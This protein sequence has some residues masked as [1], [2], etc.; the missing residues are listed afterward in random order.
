MGDQLLI[1]VAQAL[2]LKLRRVDNLFRLGG[3]E[4]VFLIEQVDSAD[5]VLDLTRRLLSRLLQPFAI[6]DQALTIGG[7][8]GIKLYSGQP[9]QTID[10]VLADAD[11]TMYRA[12]AQRN[13][14]ACHGETVLHQ[15][16]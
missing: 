3:D 11:S 4:F 14:I 8:F 13:C 12:K 10:Q 6:D 16:S 1:Q 9:C 15:A 7:S 5:T 2:R